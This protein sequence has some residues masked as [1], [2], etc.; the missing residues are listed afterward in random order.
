MKQLIIAIISFFSLNTVSSQSLNVHL[1]SGDIVKYDSSN[2]DYVDFSENEDDEE[3][4][5]LGVYY[6]RKGTLLEG[7]FRLYDS[8]NVRFNQWMSSYVYYNIDPNNQYSANGFAV[9]SNGYDH[10]AFV[11]YYNGDNWLGYEK[12]L[13]VE[14]GPYFQT[15]KVTLN[16][17]KFCDK[18]IIITQKDYPP[19]LHEIT[20]VREKKLMKVTKTDNH[21][22]VRT[23]LNN[24]EDIITD[25]L[26]WD[27]NNY[28]WNATYLGNKESTD[29]IILN[30]M[31]HRM[32][33][34]T[35]PLCITDPAPWHLW[36]QHGYCIPTVDAEHTLTS[37]DIGSVWKDQRDREYRIGAINGNRIF[38]L[39]TIRETVFEGVF[40]RDWKS[41][42]NSNN[43][44]VTTLSHISSAIHTNTI[45][46]TT[47]SDTQLR[48]MMLLDS[49]LFMA[50]GI[51]ITE[52]GIYYCDE[53]VISEVLNC[54]DPWTVETWFPSPIQKEI[55]A[56]L[57][58]T[59]TIHGLASMYDTVLDMKKPYIFSWYGANQV[60]HFVPISTMS[61][62]DVYGMMPRAKKGNYAFPYLANDLK[63]SGEWVQRRESDLYDIDKQPDRYITF[64]MSPSTGNMKI[65]CAS[66]L[67]LIR[68]IT[69]DS[70]RNKVFQ[71]YEA[72]D[73]DLL[74]C[75]PSNR[76]KAYF[77]VLAD[78]HFENSI[79]PANYKAQ[80]STYLCYF[81]PMANTGQ[82]Y[83]YK[84]G[85]DYIIYAHY[86]EEH[87]KLAINLP[88]EMEGL[89]VDVVDKTDGITLLTN[90][91]KNG[92]VYIT[93][94]ATDHN[95][96]VLKTK[97]SQEQEAH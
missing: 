20:S 16:V 4:D 64:F 84:D 74:D 35:G 15:E 56:V 32:G 8:G 58:Q 10:I 72:G 19:V 68:G 41:P 48:S 42:T 17:P 2:F 86:Q 3:S 39:P 52:N 9:P 63:R 26:L 94:D 33:D 5:V 79:I 31:I 91:I 82:V 60:Q 38:L 11:H 90:E 36:A 6:I 62:Y 50:D 59:F 29:E 83:W 61:G 70:L 30:N 34:S 87:N 40:T 81:D 1:K 25:Y 21:I 13:Y 12:D 73:R 43:P 93:A 80:F 89:S 27:N 18:I 78:S 85:E 54:T 65:G 71:V 75:S 88:K 46:C 24:K 37:D 44:Q 69:V 97:Q 47:Y 95:Y 49:R 55:G 66:G 67:S 51:E 14:R 77:K 57:T 92:Q 45:S 7:Q 53:F 23:A 76:N 96:I 28:T 22:F